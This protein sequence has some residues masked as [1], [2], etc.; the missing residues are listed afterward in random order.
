MNVWGGKREFTVLQ[1]T[2]I[3]NHFTLFCIM[4]W[5]ELWFLF[6]DWQWILFDSELFRQCVNE[7][8]FMDGWI[9]WYCDGYNYNAMCFR[10]RM[11]QITKWNMNQIYSDWIQVYMT[12]EFFCTGSV[13]CF[14]MQIKWFCRWWLLCE[15]FCEWEFPS[16]F[17]FVFSLVIFQ[18]LKP[19]AFLTLSHTSRPKFP[20]LPKEDT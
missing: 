7:M 2:R 9:W 12:G 15:K 1:G 5:L 8:K 6:E 13:L 14:Q 17:E 18:T 11:K 4:I 10:S 16:K 3:P 19:S 20:I